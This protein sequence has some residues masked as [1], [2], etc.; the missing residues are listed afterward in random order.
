VLRAAARQQKMR[1]CIGWNQQKGID[2]AILAGDIN[3]TADPSSISWTA[4]LMQSPNSKNSTADA[5]VAQEQLASETKSG[6]KIRSQLDLDDARGQLRKG[7]IGKVVLKHGGG[8]VQANFPN[9]KNL[10]IHKSEFEKVEDPQN[11][12]PDDCGQLLAREIERCQSSSKK[13][14]SMQL[15]S[16]TTEMLQENLAESSLRV[17]LMSRLDGCPSEIPVET[18]ALVHDVSLEDEERQSISL[19]G[20]KRLRLQDMPVGSFPTYRL[21]ADIKDGMDLQPLPDPS[22]S[23]SRDFIKGCYFQ[24][25]KAGVLKKRGDMTRLNLGWLDRL[26]VGID[27][28]RLAADVSVTQGSLAMLRGVA[29]GKASMTDHAMNSWTVV[30]RT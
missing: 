14:D 15:S 24:G 1:Q 18:S 22:E 23:V 16:E 7:D 9:F 5:E 20:I 21:H 17:S 19:C 8:K 29:D 3:C 25:P 26:Y 6:D 10:V 30:I 27:E 11:A 12:R 28:D 13:N 2:V 4:E